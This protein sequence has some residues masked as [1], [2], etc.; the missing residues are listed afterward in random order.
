MFPTWDSSVQAQI[1]E[2]W[3]PQGP[4]TLSFPPQAEGQ[5]SS[6]DFT[7]QVPARPP[8]R[9]WHLVSHPPHGRPLPGPRGA[10]GSTVGSQGSRGR[11]GGL[12]GRPFTT[13]RLRACT[14]GL[15]GPPPPPVLPGG[16]LA[17]LPR[18]AG[19]RSHQ[20]HARP[21]T[22][23][24]RRRGRF[25]KTWRPPP[26]RPPAHRRVPGSPAFQT[27]L[28]DTAFQGPVD[29]RPAALGHSGHT[30]GRSAAAGGDAPARAPSERRP[31]PGGA[32]PGHHTRLGTWGRRELPRQVVPP[33]GRVPGADRCTQ[34]PHP[35]SW[36]PVLFCSGRG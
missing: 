6:H 12:P 33:P 17:P 28:T 35:L 19:L 26:L 5:P 24:R 14:Q 25:T 10:S 18:E 11:V 7:L 23:P 21:R 29:P 34:V 4:R 30:R 1:P 15:Q 3:D 16:S 9:G 32:G 31:P 22:C 13:P 2:G 27:G 8:P 20:L 36:P